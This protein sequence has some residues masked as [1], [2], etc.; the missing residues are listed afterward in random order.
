MKKVLALLLLLVCPFIGFAN[1]EKNDSGK[2]TPEPGKEDPVTVLSSTIPLADPFILYH[3]GLYYL[4]GTHVGNGFDVYFSKDL[5]HW[6]RA[7]ALALSHTDSYGSSQ[8]WAPEVYYVEKE[9]KFYIYYSTEEHVCV[10]TSDSP[11][12]PFK[13]DEKKP[14]R[15]EKGIDTSVFFDDDGKAY[16]YFVRFTDGN[17]I[18][19]AELEDNLKDIKEETLVQ[20]IV[21]EDPWEVIYP[22]VVEGPSILK[23]DGVYYLMYSAN[24]FRSQDYAAGYA[25][26]NS[27]FGPWKKYEKNPVLHRYEG[28][29]GVGHG[30]PFCDK[31]GKMRYVFHAHNSETQV[32][33]RNTYIVDMSLKGGAISMGGNLIRPMIVNKLP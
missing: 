6:E 31:D 14:I 26:S 15:E 30:A 25:T 12:G 21:A 22:K 27:P 20:C 11:L 2:D 24:H 5:E 10:A 3:D 33:P 18:W 1:C 23:Q 16:L 4:Y 17:V 13:Q 7:S 29:F 32:S 28:L 9:K 19:C 8:Y